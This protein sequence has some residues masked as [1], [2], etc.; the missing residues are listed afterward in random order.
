MIQLIPVIH[1]TELNT[2]FRQ[3]Y[4][5]TFPPDERR[6]WNKL[7]ELIGNDHF[8]LNEI[9][10]QEKFAGFISIWNLGEF[11]FIEH[12]AIRDTER[13]KGIGTRII[14]Q[15]IAQI[16]TP[17]ILE[18]EEPHTLSARKRIGFYERLNFWVSDGD[19]CQPPYAIDK[20]K[21]KML[22]MSY[23]NRIQPENF[24][25]IKNR[26]HDVVYQYHEK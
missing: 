14:R 10:H 4:E 11:S 6:E 13:G 26:I 8:S 1:P 18:V 21:V 15:I 9:Y 22:L 7:T 16:S 20:N 19:Y 25:G 24:A 2:D 17:V 12:F 23:P 5:E 3:I